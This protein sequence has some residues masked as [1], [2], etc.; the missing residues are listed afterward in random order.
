MSGRSSIDTP[1]RELIISGL[2]YLPDVLCDKCTEYIVSE[3]F[4]PKSPI[5]E[6][7]KSRAIVNIPNN[8]GCSTFLQRNSVRHAPRPE[9]A[10]HVSCVMVERA[11]SF[12]VARAE[13]RHRSGLQNRCYPQTSRRLADEDLRSRSREGL[14]ARPG[15]QPPKTPHQHG[16]RI[17]S[18]R[19]SRAPPR[20]DYRPQ[21]GHPDI[22]ASGRTTLQ[23]HREDL[24]TKSP[25]SRTRS[26]GNPE[27]VPFVSVHQSVYFSKPVPNATCSRVPV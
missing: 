11:S 25:G 2:T 18:I 15:L 1:A 8:V 4:A 3:L 22:P 10:G 20:M 14:A 19:Q 24:P 26:S 16:L 6:C 13:D 12:L 21:H 9:A 5:I 17:A 27:G 7:I 23:A